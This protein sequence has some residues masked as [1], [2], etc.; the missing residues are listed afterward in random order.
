MLNCCIVIIKEI[1]RG[2]KKCCD[3]ADKTDK[4]AF[5]SIM[6]LAVLTGV[7]CFIVFTAVTPF[8]GT[9]DSIYRDDLPPEEADASAASAGGGGGATEAI[10]ESK[11]TNK[12]A[13]SILAG[14]STQGNPSYGP[15]PANAASDALV[16]WVNEDTVPHTAT[17]GKGP[18]DP[19]SGKLFDSS[20]LTPQGKF[21]VTAE[22]L[23]KGEHPYYCTVHPYMKGTITVT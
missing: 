17:S 1:N 3:M 19:E 14:A 4:V 7:V 11:F 15:D 8:P 6:G 16:T 20:I 13:V 9:V 2:I 18:E 23:G 10:D 22:K 21:S 12:V 5:M